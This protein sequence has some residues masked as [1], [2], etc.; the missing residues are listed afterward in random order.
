[1]FTVHFAIFFEVFKFLMHFA[2]LCFLS[3]DLLEV[4]IWND[5]FVRYMCNMY[6]FPLS[7]AFFLIF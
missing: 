4:S 7:E 1:M 3:Y 6:F 5:S 2:E